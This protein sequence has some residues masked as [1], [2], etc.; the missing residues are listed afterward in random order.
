MKRNRCI[1]WLCLSRL[2]SL[3]QA[4]FQHPFDIEGY[5]RPIHANWPS[6]VQWQSF[7][8]SLGGRLE[9]LRPWAAVCY[10][11]DPL[12][13]YTDCEEVLSGY[14]NDHARTQA[15][16]AL[17][18][19]NWESCGYGNGCALRYGDSQVA[20]NS[21]CHQGT[22]PPFGIAI[23]NSQDASDVVKW[24]LA[25]HV[26]LTVKN[27]GHDFLGRSAVPWTLQV[28]THKMQ[29]LEYIPGF[30]PE[31]SKSPAVPAITMG[32]GAQLS[33][34][35]AFAGEKNV[36][37]VL[38]TCPTVGAGGFFQA[39]GHGPLT[40]A[41][42]LGAQHV[43][44]FELVTADGQIRRINEAQDPDLFW[45][46]RG[47]GSGSWGIITSITIQAYPA[48]E[49]SIS[50]LTIEPNT[51]QDK[52]RLAISFIALVGQYQNEWINNG[53]YSA[54]FPAEEQYSLLLS[55]PSHTASLSILFPF[56][57][58]L[59]S[60]SGNFTVTSNTTAAPM[61][62]SISE[63]EL[64]LLGPEAESISPYGASIQMSSRL[65]PQSSLSSPESAM[66]V[67]EEIWAGVQRI[68]AVLDKY[69]E[70]TFGPASPLILG[71]TPGESMGPMVNETGANPA[72]YQAAWH[73]SFG[74]SWT[75]GISR[76]TEDALTLAIQGATDP[77]TAMGI[78]GSYQ[79]EGS[80]FEADWRESFFGYKYSKL[81]D[82]KRN[83][84]PE[85]FFN[86]YKG[87]D[88]TSN[89]PAYQCYEANAV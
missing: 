29:S 41:L 34:V 86:S 12:F 87:V 71:S 25:N 62:S 21:A 37:V 53:I 38:G 69:P 61:F 17:L 59:R 47:G 30:V 56:F 81:L 26:K 5:V 74:S 23:S 32:G 75:V 79:A 9:A 22:T 60:L 1:Q 82:I 13:D 11:S 57:E 18:W 10:S 80:A 78:I 45:A 68:N 73:V 6:Q 39:G 64:M 65:I 85:N 33:N 70:G 36:S 51:T 89:L 77:L 84:D 35:Y 15:P 42:G 19:P 16:S 43:L 40:P 67:A 54:F 4:A 46:V 72:L 52:A 7:N 83:Y 8:E 28:N 27:T 44:E 14:D 2:V 58:E 63:A 50:S 48:M 49:I 76:E 24:A 20:N 66:K 88:W 3:S 55:W 31:G